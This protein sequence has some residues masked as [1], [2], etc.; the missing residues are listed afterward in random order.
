M[1]G[2]N[3]EIKDAGR[4]TKRRLT[5]YSLV[6]GAAVVVALLFVLPTAA[7]APMARAV[8]LSAPYYGTTTS[9][10]NSWSASGCGS[11]AI[12]ATPFFHP[13]NGLAG[14]ADQ[15]R[16]TA[17]THNPL[18][19]SGGASSGFTTLFPLTFSK[20]KATIVVVTT[21]SAVLHAHDSVGTCS[22]S[23][24]NY[25]YCD[26]SAYAELTGDAYLYDQTTGSYWFPTTFWSGAFVDAYNETFCYSGNCSTYGAPSAS[27]SVSGA[28]VFT[29]PATGLNP[30]DSFVLL[31][32]F[33]GYASVSVGTYAATLS[34]GSTSASV[35]VA[36]M[37]HGI[38]VASITIT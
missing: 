17:C 5:S 27:A 25:Y 23:Q 28:V 7:A 6:A 1:I 3:A 18:G 30:A 14:F 31:L 11:A 32:F 10:S 22:A 13:S 33:S 8:V 20:S 24:T 38:N 34:G 29:I 19:G 37:G 36:T 12:T 16:S 35:N 9:Y 15:A 21:V 2:T 4:S 26:S